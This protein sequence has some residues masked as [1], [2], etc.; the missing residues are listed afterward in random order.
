MCLPNYHG[1]GDWRVVYSMVT[2]TYILVLRRWYRY[3]LRYE[4][5]D[6]NLVLAKVF[7]AFF[8]SERKE[9]KTSK[10]CTINFCARNCTASLFSL[11]YQQF[12]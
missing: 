12:I 8:R 2:V 5:Y 11:L 10:Y 1:T 3:I 6:I 7:F 4:V 9:S